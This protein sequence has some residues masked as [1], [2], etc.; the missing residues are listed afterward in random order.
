MDDKHFTIDTEFIISQTITEDEDRNDQPY[1]V[2]DVWELVGCEDW[3]DE[4]ILTYLDGP[5]WF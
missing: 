2:I 3:S 4:E 5:Y 1:Y